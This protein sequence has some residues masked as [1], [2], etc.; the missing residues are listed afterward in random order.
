MNLTCRYQSARAAVMNVLRILAIAIV[1]FGLIEVRAA[2]VS[3][4]GST[5]TVAQSQAGS[6][7]VTAAGTWTFGAS[8]NAYGNSVLLNGATNGGFATLLE[9][10]NGGQLYAQAGDSSWWK[11]NNP[12]W[13]FSTAPSGG[14]VSPDGST[15]TFT[16]S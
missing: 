3:A 8:S 13:S 5:L 7:L 11:W 9:V 4:D 16:Q 12:G 14:H 10:A 1:A 15:L 6:S 2:A